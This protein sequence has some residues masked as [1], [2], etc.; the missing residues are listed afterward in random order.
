MCLAGYHSSV[1]PALTPALTHVSATCKSRPRTECV[2]RY[3]HLVLS[4][5]VL[6]QVPSPSCSKLVQLNSRYEGPCTDESQMKGH[7]RPEGPR[8]DHLY[9]MLRRISVVMTMHMAL[10]L[11]ATS[12]V[13]SP[14]SVNSSW[15]SRYFWLLNACAK[16]RP[17]PKRPRAGWVNKTGQGPARQYEL[18]EHSTASAYGRDSSRTLRQCSIIE[19][20]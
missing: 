18:L 5:D 11:M 10:G 2:C 13:I 20:V 4:H 14:T 8:H 19:A 9:S 1:D 6:Q 16:H 7:R 3:A 12:P 15:S 17:S